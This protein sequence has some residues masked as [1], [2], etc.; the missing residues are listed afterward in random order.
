MI[1]LKKDPHLPAGGRSPSIT[2]ALTR[3]KMQYAADAVLR[4]GLSMEAW[5]MLDQLYVSGIMTVD[6]IG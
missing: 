3:Q 4:R 5:R 1:R 2:Q 6:Q